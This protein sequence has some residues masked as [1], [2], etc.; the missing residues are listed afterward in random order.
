M[1]TPSFNISLSN[2]I[3]SQIITLLL[4]KKTIQCKETEDEVEYI[5]LWDILHI[6]KALK[7]I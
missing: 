7:D 6:W 2:Q 3:I 5:A 4:N 1:P